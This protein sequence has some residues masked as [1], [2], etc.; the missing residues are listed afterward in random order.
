LKM[1]YLADPKV[2]SNKH[3]GPW[4]LGALPEAASDGG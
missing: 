3:H 4:G 2:P 1:A